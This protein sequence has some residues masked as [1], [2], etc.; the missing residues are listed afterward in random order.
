MHVFT[1]CVSLFLFQIAVIFE[2]VKMKINFHI[3]TVLNRNVQ[4]T[5][6]SHQC[7]LYNCHFQR[8]LFVL[9]T[10]LFFCFG[11]EASRQ[12]TVSPTKCRKYPSDQEKLAV[13]FEP[14][15]KTIVVASPAKQSA[16]DGYPIVVSY[17]MLGMQLHCYILVIKV[18]VLL[19][20]LSQLDLNLNLQLVLELSLLQK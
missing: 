16:I 6:R 5:T 14:V 20:Y 18:N 3:I 2:N 1:H 4:I 15:T 17:N 11:L 8:Y 12:Y 7:K 13:H 10:L 19:Y 9:F